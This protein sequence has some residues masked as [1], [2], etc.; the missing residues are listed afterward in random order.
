MNQPRSP[1]R[2]PLNLSGLPL[3]EPPSDGWPIIEAALKDAAQGSSRRRYGTFLAAAAVVTLAVGV[4]YQQGQFEQEPKLDA[5]STAMDT[6]GPL[7]AVEKSPEPQLAMLDSLMGMSQK[8]ERNL[9]LMR[10]GV[11]DLPLDSMM[12]QVE[13]QDLVAQVDDALSLTP[14]SEE[15][16]GQRVNLLV[17]L[18]QLY[19]G[20]LRRE[21]AQLASL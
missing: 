8:L 6:Q 17:D 3:I 2:D 21:Q 10:S 7:A 20:Q 19:Q 15:L 12:L 5:R 11:G 13:L 14:D 16:W 18:A 9:R 1:Q 4:F